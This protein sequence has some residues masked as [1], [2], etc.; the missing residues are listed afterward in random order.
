M[1]SATV[2]GVECMLIGC[3]WGALVLNEFKVAVFGSPCLV[4]GAMQLLLLF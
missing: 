4:E 1:L 2:E 3:R